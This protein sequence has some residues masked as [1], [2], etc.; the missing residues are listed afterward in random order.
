MSERG[1]INL[2]ESIFWHHRYEAM[3][4]GKRVDPLVTE[5]G[6]TLCSWC[7]EPIILV[8]PKRDYRRRAR[9]RHY[10]DEYEVGDRD[11]TRAFLHSYVFNERQLIEVRGDRN[12]IDCGSEGPWEA[13]H[14]EP[15]WKGGKHCSSNI[16]R[17]C[18]LCHREKTKREATERAALRREE[19]GL[20]DPLP[21]IHPGQVDLL[22]AAA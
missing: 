10:G 21:A 7:G 22:A 19:R 5:D 1:R 14:D 6:D 12:C 13:D 3:V 8:D 20:P 9:R 18:V 15:L 16:V 4:A 2:Y 11:C 17:R